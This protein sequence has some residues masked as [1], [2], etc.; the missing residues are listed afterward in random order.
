MK[1]SEIVDWLRAHHE[2]VHGDPEAVLDQAERD[3]RRHAAEQAWLRARQIAERAME[4]WKVRTGGMHAREDWAAREFCHELAREMRHLEPHP[5]G[6]ET[7]LVDRA[8]LDAFES[9]AREQLRAW[10]QE[11]AGEEEHRVWREV[12]RYTDTRA[13][14]LIGDGTLSKE[15]RW[16]LT[17]SYAETAARLA[18]VLAHDFEERSVSALRGG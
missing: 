9:D 12:V 17:H 14:S 10:V 1:R 11:V 15:D 8:T 16:E 18:A 6:D 5:E 13:R 7:V 2:S 4:T 3:A